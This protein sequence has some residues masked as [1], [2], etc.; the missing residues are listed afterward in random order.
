MDRETQRRYLREV[1]GVPEEEILQ[2]QK[3]VDKEQEKK[4]WSFSEA[5]S[6]A[7]PR[8]VEKA[9]AEKRAQSKKNGL[10]QKF[11]NII[12]LKK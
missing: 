11:K 8:M 4:K 12:H 7:V 6:E 5:F 3:E 10:W 9:E 2:L 1:L